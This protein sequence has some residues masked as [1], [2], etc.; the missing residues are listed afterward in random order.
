[1]RSA[2]HLPPKA[3]TNFRLRQLLRVVSRMYDTEMAKAGLKGTQFSLLASIATLG[4]VQ[5]N[6]LA[7]RMDLDAST[8]TRNLR[9]MIYQG[10][11]EQRLGS[12]ARSR[13]IELTS[14]GRD[15]LG[16]ARQHWKKAQLLL[17]ER[18]GLERVNA[19]HLL[20]DDGLQL[21]GESHIN[22]AGRVRQ[23]KPGPE[24]Q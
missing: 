16:E 4:P 19:L 24:D 2:I 7:R 5:P 14:A 21:L 23:T 9:P 8:L 11:A 1:M 10:W 20:I 22:H 15:K 6:E 12:D 17:N 13:L 18:L 3:C